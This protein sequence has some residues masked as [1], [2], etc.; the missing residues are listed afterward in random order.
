MK[1]DRLDHVFILESM[2]DQTGIPILYRKK[3]VF[4]ICMPLLKQHIK[5]KMK[6]AFAGN[7]NYYSAEN[8]TK[9]CM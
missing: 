4:L 8:V 9:T 3:K 2:K 7:V 5:L 6:D 1:V